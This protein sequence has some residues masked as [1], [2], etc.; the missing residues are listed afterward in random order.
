MRECT[1]WQLRLFL[2]CWIGLQVAMAGAGQLDN[3]IATQPS[4]YRAAPVDY[5]VQKMSQA[6]YLD[7]YER[8]LPL[9]SYHGVVNYL[10]YAWW[11]WGAN[12][13]YSDTARFGHY[14][15]LVA[16]AQDV[17][18]FDRPFMATALW[19]HHKRHFTSE[20]YPQMVHFEHLLAGF[21][22]LMPAEGLLHR[23]W[24]QHPGESISRL[25]DN[26]CAT[27]SGN[28]Q[29]V[30]LLCDQYSTIK[31]KWL[32]ER[33]QYNPSNSSDRA[34]KE[35]LEIL[36]YWVRSSLMA[37]ITGHGITTNS[38]GAE[39]ERFEPWS[40]ALLQRENSLSI[41]KAFY[42]EAKDQLIQ[43]LLK[44]QGR[45]VFHDM[46]LEAASY[47]FP[48]HGLGQFDLQVTATSLEGKLDDEFI[49]TLAERL[50][51]LK[52]GESLI[53]ELHANGKG[54][55][56]SF[57]A[58]KDPESDRVMLFRAV[59]MESEWWNDTRKNWYRWWGLTYPK[60]ALLRAARSTFGVEADSHPVIGIT[61][62]DVKSL[63]SQRKAVLQFLQKTKE[64]KDFYYGPVLLM[65][66]T[67]P[68]S[69]GEPSESS[70]PSKDINHMGD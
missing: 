60:Y 21:A 35:Q 1:G 3:F 63:T 7:D 58:S 15:S 44:D 54:R 10:Y 33:N 16:M 62:K 36:V 17:A 14:P 28:S 18:Q 57:F 22:N 59:Q 46:P 68:V 51:L 64:G 37:E 69:G 39:P 23:T 47:P 19:Q 20:F 48:N 61:F 67:H 70:P 27:T 32:A 38:D 2:V 45:Y 26:A 49:D 31:Q 55:G 56:R 34:C 66:V 43:P 24:K 6:F 13:D 52:E 65:K 30:R 41:N 25:I 5:A 4:K 8:I 11:K 42:R 50:L 53:L 9:A 40:P 29:E 12:A